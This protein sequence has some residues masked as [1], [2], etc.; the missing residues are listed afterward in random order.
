MNTAEID[1][2]YGEM[3]VVSVS[4][5][6][7]TK[8]LS[9]SHIAVLNDCF[10]SHH[11]LCVR[12]QTLTPYQLVA[13]GRVFG[14]P[15]VQLLG[16]YRLDDPPEV[17]VISNYNKLGGEKP[18]VRAT[19]WHTDDSYFACPAKATMLFSLAIPSSGGS[20]QFID[21]EAVL[22]AMPDA[23]RRSIEGRRAVHKYH[24][25]RGK[26]VVAVRTPEEEALTPDV[27]HPLIRMHPE[28]GRE[29]L[30]INPNRI[31]HIEGLSLAESDALLDALYDFAFDARFQYRHHWQLGDLIIWDNR[32]TMHR[33][34]TDFDVN[35]R[36]EFHRLLLQGSVPV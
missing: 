13:A 5:V 1:I 26:A 15:Q 14:A 8:P 17:S 25:R 21:T 22:K 20:T 4:G 9:D 35:E 7:L 28:T 19:H 32:C 33:A 27:S 2:E 30:Y 23:M 29:A 31:D 12:G 10:L 24:S 11:I 36:R 16:D 34:S 18:H 3:R 6:D